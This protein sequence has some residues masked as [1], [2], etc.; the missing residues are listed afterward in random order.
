VKDLKISPYHFNRKL[1]PI[2]LFLL[3]IFGGWLLAGCGQSQPIS[4]PPPGPALDLEYSSAADAPLPPEDVLVIPFEA[5]TEGSDSPDG[6]AIAAFVTE[7][8]RDLFEDEQGRVVA[9][10]GLQVLQRAA[11]AYQTYRYTAVDED[12]VPWPP[13]T[14]LSLLVKYRLLRALPA[15]PAGQKF[16]I[17]PK[18]HQVALVP[19]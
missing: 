5:A 7:E 16:I 8:N 4:A 13:L 6:G 18:T 1:E 10:S 2:L 3:L 15:A 11:E 9:Q 17:D 12:A 14:D 19:Q